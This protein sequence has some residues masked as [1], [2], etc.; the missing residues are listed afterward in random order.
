MD[1]S[2]DPRP[3]SIRAMLNYGVDTWEVPVNQT[4]DEGGPSRFMAG[5]LA[6]HEMEIADARAI[7]DRLTLDGNGFV[8]V[9]HPTQV[10]DFYSA[11]QIRDIYYQEMIGLVA[12]QSGA[13]RVVV[14]DHT[15]RHGEEA[16]RSARKLREPVQRVHNDYTEWSGPQ[17]VRDVMGDE[18]DDLLR[19]RFA[20]IQVWRPINR[21]VERD[22]LAFAD[23]GSVAFEDLIISERRYPGRVGQTY[24]VKHNPAHRW[25][26]APAMRRDEAFVFK[27]Y[28]S[29]KDGRVRFTAHTAFPPP[30]TPVNAPPRES[31]EIRTL[32]FF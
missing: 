7:R 17:R 15:L 25:L 14:F 16:E 21:P 2:T 6:A 30:S 20:V 11:D 24:L 13:S 28:D 1:E 18:A 19:R 9:D 8:L 5:R 31:I 12:A 23:G 29:A 3:S 27:V 4:F 26:Y 32:A 22:P 10:T